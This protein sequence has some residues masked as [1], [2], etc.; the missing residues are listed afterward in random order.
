MSTPTASLIRGSPT[1]ARGH[2]KKVAVKRPGA[3]RR[4]L[5]RVLFLYARYRWP[6]GHGLRLKAL[7]PDVRSVPSL[8]SAGR[9]LFQVLAVY[10]RR[11][12]R[13]ENPTLSSGPS[14]P[15]SGRALTLN[16][17]TLVHRSQ[18]L[19]WYALK[20]RLPGRGKPCPDW[21]LPSCIFQVSSSFKH[22]ST[23][24]GRVL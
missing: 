20:R 13:T 21:R 7:L 17:C 15:L 3:M 16:G 24:T 4:P 23:A 9:R 18:A 8:T 1:T 6:A 14:R 5:M 2:T 12:A 19:F 22:F 10:V 11:T